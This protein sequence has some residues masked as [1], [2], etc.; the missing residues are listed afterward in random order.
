M[1][2]VQAKVRLIS[3]TPSALQL[4]S[5]SLRQ[6]HCYDPDFNPFQSCTDEDIKL[7]KYALKMG[8]LSAF[9]HVVFSFLLTGISR[10][11]SHQLV[12]H[13]IASYSQ[14][15]QRYVGAGDFDV[16]MP[17]MIRDNAEAR[18]VFEKAMKAVEDAYNELEDIFS[19]DGEVNTRDV[20]RSVLPNATATKIVVTMNVRSLLNFFKLRLGDGAE[21]EIR[22]V[23][24]QMLS[25]CQNIL[26]EVFN[27]VQP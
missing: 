10:S 20:A 1:I 22:Q 7:I 3:L 26:P 12:R 9:E 18:K 11:C 21:E 19:E 13:R 6:C 15:S 5:A 2:F 27:P 23:A 24:G 4:I 17:K 8:H 25:L 16:V 14:Q